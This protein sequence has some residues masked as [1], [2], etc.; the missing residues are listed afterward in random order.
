MWI[1][2]K[3]MHQEMYSGYRDPKPVGAGSSYRYGEMREEVCYRDAS[4]LKRKV[5]N[6][7]KGM[8]LEVRTHRKR[9]KEE[10]ETENNLRYPTVIRL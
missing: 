4:L 7:G 10:V 2:G 8:R 6:Y 9:N 1:R 5:T 3:G